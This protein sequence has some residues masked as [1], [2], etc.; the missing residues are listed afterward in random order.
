[1]ILLGLGNPGARYSKSRHNVGFKVIDE[2]SRLLSIQLKKP[3][4]KPFALGRG[5]VKGE[6]VFLAKP[7]TYMNKSGSIILPLLDATKEPVDKL[8]VVCDNLDLPPG[9]CRLKRGGSSA[10]QRGL[11][12]ILQALGT[13][14][15]IRLFIGIGRPEKQEEV[16]EYVLGNPM[17]EEAATINQACLRGAQGIVRLLETNLEQVMNEI[18]RR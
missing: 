1:M 12:S 9:V 8:I 3:L 6:K 18:N 13:D 4:F 16:V 10:G 7:L 15:F 14:Q 2:V 17:G 11:N 5:E